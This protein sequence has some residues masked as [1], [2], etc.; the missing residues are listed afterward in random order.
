MYLDTK[1][2]HVCKD[3]TGHIN[4]RCGRCVGVEEEERI[5]EWNALDIET[6]IND[7][8][9]RIEQLERGPRRY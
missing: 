9:K 7:L 5:R 3:R 4:G 8:R 2:C 6:R 1:Y